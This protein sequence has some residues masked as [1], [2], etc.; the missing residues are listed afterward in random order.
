MFRVQ[1]PLR[2]CIK[3]LT[4]IAA[5]VVPLPVPLHVLLIWPLSYS[6]RDKKT[7]SP[8]P[9][10]GPRYPKP[11]TK[12]D[13]AG[14][15]QVGAGILVPSMPLL[16]Q[17]PASH[18]ISQGARPRNFLGVLGVLRQLG[19]RNPHRQN[20][21]RVGASQLQGHAKGPRTCESKCERIS[22]CSPC[23]PEVF[24]DREE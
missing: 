6:F 10:E 9:K 7:G 2:A 20:A 8:K 3:G 22:A 24:L 4:V 19:Q 18:S 23:T 11:E 16:Q 17:C 14:Q 1:G 12:P 5:Q 13:T 21:G 15:G